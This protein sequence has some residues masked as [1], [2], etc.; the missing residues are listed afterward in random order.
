MKI[1]SESKA[2]E[3]VREIKDRHRQTVKSGFEHRAKDCDSCET[4][5]ACCI[6]AHFVNVRVSRLEAVLMKEA[7]KTLS[8]EAMTGVMRRVAESIE[9]FG[10]EEASAATTYACPLFDRSV[11]CL[12]HDVKPLPCVQHACYEKE[13]DLPPEEIREEAELEI[14]RITRRTYGKSLPLLSIPLAVRD[15]L[16]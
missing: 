6:D 8:P 9:R 11:G 14:D 2:L 10:L 13:T 16:D 12:V 4:K 3:A 5:G 1:L 7:L 15:L